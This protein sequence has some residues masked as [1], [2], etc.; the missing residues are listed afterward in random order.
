MLLLLALI[1]FSDG[2]FVRD[3][4]RNHI[5][6]LASD[7]MRGRASGQP[8]QKIAA[9][10][11]AM[12]LKKSGLEPGLP[13]QP[14]PWFQEFEL[15]FTDKKQGATKLRL[16]GRGKSLEW[17][18]GADFDGAT[19]QG[20]G[21][22]GSGGMVF[23]G[24]GLETEGYNDFS[25]L[26]IKGRWVIVMA[27]RP[28]SDGPIFGQEEIDGERGFQKVVNAW[29]REA[30]GVI[31]ISEGG[32]RNI[33][34]PDVALAQGPVEEDFSGFPFLRIHRSQSADLFGKY[35]KRFLRSLEHIRQEEKP[36]S[37]ALKGRSLQLT[38][39]YSSEY[40]VGKNIVGVIP[41]SDPALANEYVVISAHYD[42]VGVRNND[43]YNGADDNA[44]GTATL[45]I[46]AQRLAKSEL[47]RSVLF[48]FAD[49]EEHGL[50]GSEFFVNNP[51]IP[52]DKIVAN[53]NFDMVGRPE[54]GAIGIIPAQNEDVSTINE[55][56][57]TINKAK[58]YDIELLETMDRL[59]HRSDHY[60]F[61]EKG[62]PAIFFMGT[63]HD[64]YHKPTDDPHLLE[65]D[66]MSHNYFL[67]EDV[68]IKLAN[69]DERPRFLPKE[70]DAK[71]SEPITRPG[72]QP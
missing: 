7:H 23:A 1:A 62:I 42:H 36:A 72:E 26:E 43:V 65:Y 64:D 27:D 3:S 66:V 46:L 28:H 15:L 44:S 34:E 71:K 14:E 49:A 13:E 22:D 48:L 58:G 5:F 37:F 50:L 6:F 47:R 55:M 61:V 11:I 63:I 39:P 35:H 68:A 59:H 2:D 54:G 56:V 60:N 21:F 41:G 29:N 69:N 9:D 16:R 40:K 70:E 24:Y 19:F 10:Y 31:I 53:I 67:Y 57:K 12:H 4:Y 30:L 38:M 17:R 8:E 51:T 18:Y 25:G 52:L 45:M 32:N 20:S 33:G